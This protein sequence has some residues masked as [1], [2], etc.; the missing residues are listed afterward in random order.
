MVDF[1]KV[2][3]KL[4]QVLQVLEEQGE[5][6]DDIIVDIVNLTEV[7]FQFFQVHTTDSLKQGQEPASPE[8]LATCKVKTELFQTFRQR[9]GQFLEQLIIKSDG[10]NDDDLLFFNMVLESEGLLDLLNDVKIEVG[11]VNYGHKILD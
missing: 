1:I 2:K 7:K 6:L 5:P 10:L 9:L 11:T 3:V 4:F 8:A